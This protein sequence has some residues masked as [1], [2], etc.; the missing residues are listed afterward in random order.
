L[1]TWLSRTFMPSTRHSVLIRYSGFKP[2]ALPCQEK[3]ANWRKFR[4]TSLKEF[5]NV[6]GCFFSRVRRG[7]TRIVHVGRQSGHL[8]SDS[9]IQSSTSEHPVGSAV[10]RHLRAP[11][12]IA[13]SPYFG[14]LPLPALDRRTAHHVSSACAALSLPARP[15]VSAEFVMDVNQLLSRYHQRNA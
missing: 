8:S 10:G 5:D 7:P 1:C 11:E 12:T 6:L 3:T 14:G 9:T 4:G 2:K 15:K 13:I